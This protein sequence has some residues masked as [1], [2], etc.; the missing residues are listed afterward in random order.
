MVTTLL[1]PHLARALDL[2]DAYHERW[3]IETTIDEV[4]THQRLI[5][6]PLRSKKPV[7]V[8]QEIYGLFLAHFILR[9]FMHQAALE[10]RIDP[11]RLSFLQTVR[12]VQ[13]ALPEF[14]MTLG[15]HLPA[16]FP[17]LLH[18]LST[19]RSPKASPPL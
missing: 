13:D 19:G 7:G 18:D 4:D 1:D 16:L 14:E 10:A 8:I 12:L 5:N 3:E 9:S 2:L 11:D 6:H 15:E 17:R